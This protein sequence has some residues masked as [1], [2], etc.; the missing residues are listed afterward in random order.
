MTPEM[1]TDQ[2]SMTAGSWLKQLFPPAVG[3][4]HTYEYG[5]QSLR[6]VASG[7]RGLGWEAEAT[8]WVGRTASLRRF[9]PT[10]SANCVWA[11][12]FV[13]PGRWTIPV[14]APSAPSLALKKSR[15]RTDTA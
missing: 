8:T 6:I 14:E 4:Q 12:L 7:S 3:Q 9:L 13:D 11:P 10:F 1:M 2:A 5:I 15:Q